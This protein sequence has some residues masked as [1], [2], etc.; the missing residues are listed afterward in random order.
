MERRKFLRGLFGGAAAVAV[1]PLAL[2]R[3]ADGLVLGGPDEPPAVQGPEVTKS[4]VVSGLAVYNALKKKT[5]Q[6]PAIT[7]DVVV[8][9]G[10]LMVSGRAPG[11][12]GGFDTLPGTPLDRGED[13]LTLLAPDHR[14]M[15][16]GMQQVADYD[17]WEFTFTGPEALVDEAMKVID[18]FEKKWRY[19]SA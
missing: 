2:P 7:Q 12:Y 13:I 19:Q 3:R 15:V 6:R 8:N 17:A 18:D 11:T 4:G 16:W 14:Q 5:E 10:G 1:A 9:S